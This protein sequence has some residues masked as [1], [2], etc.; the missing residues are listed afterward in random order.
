MVDT[1]AQLFLNTVKS[2]PKDDLFLYKKEEAYIPMSTQAVSE[3]VK[4]FALGL[5]AL[6]A[7]AGDKLIILAENS[8]FWLMTDVSNLCI[9]GISVPIYTSLMPEQIKYIID[10]SDAKIV[11][12]SSPELWDK[13]KDIKDDLTKVNAF[14]TFQTEAP[15][16]TKTVAEVQAKGKELETEQPAL[17]EKLAGEVR[18][19]DVASIIYTS[20]T[21]GVPKGVMLTHNNFISNVKAVDEVIPFSPEDTALSFLPLSHVLERMV[22]FVYLYEGI[23]IGYAESIETLGVNL[24][25]IRPTL[26]VAVPRIFEKIYAAVIDNVLTSSSLK[27]KIF[28]WAAKIGKEYGRLQLLGDPIPGALGFKHKVAHKLVFSKIIA[29]TGGNVRFFVSGGA[30]LSKDIAE[31]FYAMGL[32]VLEGYGLTETS[33][34]ITANTFD[35]LKFG[36]VGQPVP[37]VEVKIAD[38]GEILTK[39]PHV[40]PGYYKMEAETAETLKGG[41]LYTGDIGY[42]D[43][44]GFLVITDRKKD[45]IV[46]AGGKNVAPQAIENILKIHPFIEGAVV[47]GDKRKFISALIVPNFEKLAE[48]AKTKDISFTDNADLISKAEIVQYYE[49]E[50]D[51]ATPDLA[52]YEKV[53]KVV[54]L[55]RDFEI[56]KGE[57]TPSLKIKRNIVEDKYKERIDALYQE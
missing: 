51:K 12:C 3:W 38:D 22:S 8:P 21:T 57:I 34:V 29:K 48:Y 23:S 32:V 7:T 18:P 1:I 36:S 6:G 11:V 37:G 52:S 45:I 54:L 49:Q 41:W 47:V 4:Y 30:A 9:G 31:F 28:F 16:G 43:E 26:M 50:I 42:L 24:T 40:M 5:R 25:E 55:D 14:I 39:G 15:P 53:K 33:P 44:Q 13:V 56:E 2:Y 27:R 46:T 35:H 19:S 20:G 17:F 10:N